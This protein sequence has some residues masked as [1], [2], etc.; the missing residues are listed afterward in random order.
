MTICFH[1]I[2]CSSRMKICAFKYSIRCSSMSD[3]FD[4][5]NIYQ[6]LWRLARDAHFAMPSKVM[7]NIAYAS[8]SLQYLSRHEDSCL[9]CQ[10][11]VGCKD[12]TSMLICMTATL[13]ILGSIARLVRDFRG[14]KSIKCFVAAA[15]EQNLYVVKDWDRTWTQVH[16]TKHHASIMCKCPPAPDSMNNKSFWS[17]SGNLR[18]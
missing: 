8:W 1:T 4:W 16:H 2:K 12:P 7:Q 14:Y 5:Y 6:Q 13:N 10:I 18:N 11:C 15:R 17:H 3:L 9:V